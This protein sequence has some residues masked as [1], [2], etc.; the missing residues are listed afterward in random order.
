MIL[1]LMK[2]AAWDNLITPPILISVPPLISIRLLSHPLIYLLFE[3]GR[4]L[5]ILGILPTWGLGQSKK[6]MK[7]FYKAFFFLGAF[8]WTLS[9][10]AQ[11]IEN[12]KAVA[13]GTKIIVTFDI[14]DPKPGQNFYNIQLYSSHDNFASP[15]TFIKGDVG[16]EVRPGA[17]KRI[18]WEAGEIG[19]FKG[20]LTFEI[21]GEIVAAWLFKNPGSGSKLT[22]GKA[23]TI[24]WQGGKPD[25]NVKIEMVK[26]GKTIPVGEG[27][28]T[29]SMSWVVP[30]DLVK[31]GGYQL[32]LTAKGNTITSDLFAVKNKMPIWMIA[33]PI[34]VVGGL[35]AVLLGGGGGGDP[36]PTDTSNDL[37][38][39][40]DPN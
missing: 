12:I 18:E 1:K 8:T 37:P 25:D 27:K 15:L 24:Q 28:N 14:K 6:R 19:N 23:A 11:T 35:A 2:I 29:G 21:R 26:D 5:K 22:K 36:G 40:P 38:T 17:G 4:G 30:K 31:G 13:Q 3:G 16:N 9:A 34:V 10:G 7:P 39:P 20:D 32:K 33:A